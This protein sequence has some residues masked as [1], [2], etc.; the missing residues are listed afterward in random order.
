MKDIGIISIILG[1]IISFIGIVAGLVVRVYWEP[2]GI[3]PSCVAVDLVSWIALVLALSALV[4]T[5]FRWVKK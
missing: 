4:I 5:V 3:F 2:N 1:T